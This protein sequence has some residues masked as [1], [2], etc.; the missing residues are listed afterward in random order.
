MNDA[1]SPAD[2]ELEA[3]L[4]AQQALLESCLPL[5]FA[6]YDQ[7]VQ[8]GLKTPVVVLVD[9]E[10]ELGGDIARAWVG[11]E[12]VDTAIAEQLHER[13]SDE[14]T[15]A[16]ARVVS[17]AEAKRE[18]PQVFPYLE[19]VFAAPP[20]DGF[21]AISITAG[22]ASALTVPPDARED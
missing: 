21:L 3:A 20:Q 5:V 13:Q 18:I 4:D 14:E 12:A 11:D 7:A 1:D 9:C 17:F 19:P 8:R 16:F 15:T 6:E 10:D 2:P 22:G